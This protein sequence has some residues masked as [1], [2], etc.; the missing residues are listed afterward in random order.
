MGSTTFEEKINNL[1]IL[2]SD[3]FP[4][5]KLLNDNWYE[6]SYDNNLKNELQK[7]ITSIINSLNINLDILNNDNSVK[8]ILSK[9]NI[10]DGKIFFYEL[11]DD[12]SIIELSTD[13]IDNIE[14]TSKN[15]IKNLNRNIMSFSRRNDKERINALKNL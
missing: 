9:E 15:E 14:F 11:L 10:E 13:E 7:I 1:N 3:L 2:L 6:V 5:L 12:Y 4:Y 8:I